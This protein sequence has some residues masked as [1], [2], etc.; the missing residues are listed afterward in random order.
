MISSLLLKKAME[1][2]VTRSLSWLHLRT[3]T[4]GVTSALVEMGQKMLLVGFGCFR[5]LRFCST[6]SYIELVSAIL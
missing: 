1:V 5:C 3:I 4:Y 2:I 6:L